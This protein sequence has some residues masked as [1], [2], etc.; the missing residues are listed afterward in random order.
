MTERGDIGDINFSSRIISTK[1]YRSQ[2]LHITFRGVFA[3]K[4]CLGCHPFHGDFLSFVDFVN[5][6]IDVA[7]QSKVRNFD[8]FALT[9]ENIPCR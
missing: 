4:K 7:H 6:S 2:H 9:K 8:H 3:V 5:F 1:V